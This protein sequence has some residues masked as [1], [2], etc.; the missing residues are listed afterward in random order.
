MSQ[1]TDG[2]MVSPLE[3]AIRKAERQ[4]WVITDIFDKITQSGESL[5]ENRKII[6]IYW[7]L[8]PGLSHDFLSEMMRKEVGVY[9]EESTIRNYLNDL[10]IPA[11]KNIILEIRPE[12]LER[13]SINKQRLWRSLQEDFCGSTSLKEVKHRYW[14]LL[15][16]AESLKPGSPLYAGIYPVAID[17]PY[18]PTIQTQVAITS[19]R[20]LRESPPLPTLGGEFKLQ[21]VT[22]ELPPLS[23]VIIL[24]LMNFVDPTSA[25][26]RERVWAAI[27]WIN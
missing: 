1:N 7:L 9:L 21:R 10:I 24:E 18:I 26:K 6:L 4:D 12:L 17:P 11:L 2:G 3:A 5:T 8:F 19:S 20:N 16:L 23:K 22:G 15:G 25:E 27:K 13:S 14:L